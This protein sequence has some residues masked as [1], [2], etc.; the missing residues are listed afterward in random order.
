MV[1]VSKQR[2]IVTL[3]D[4]FD[5][6]HILATGQQYNRDHP[7]QK[8]QKVLVND[9]VVI[10]YPQLLKQ[11]AARPTR[12]PANLPAARVSDLECRFLH[13]MRC[14]LRRNVRAFV[15]LVL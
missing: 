10:N 12:R 2:A 13:G 14:D 15:E 4:G 5:P 3:E 1:L 9:R 11:E 6:S 8:I 7:T